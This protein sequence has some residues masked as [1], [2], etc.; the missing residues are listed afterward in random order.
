[1]LISPLRRLLMRRLRE[2]LL[3]MPLERR[4]RL[5]KERLESNWML[6][7]LSKL[8]LRLKWQRSLTVWPLLPTIRR[9]SIQSSQ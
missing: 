2:K 1:M 9:P 3:K 4:K 5:P 8:E 6:K 7:L